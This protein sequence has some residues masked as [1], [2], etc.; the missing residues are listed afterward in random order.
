[1]THRFSIVLIL[2]AT[3]ACAQR[4]SESK[5]SL[6]TFG[7]L[8]KQHHIQLT[9]P[10]LSEALRNP[11][12]EVRDLAAQK[13]AE[14]KAY[15]AIPAINAALASEQVPRTRMNIAFAIAQLGET[16]GFDVLERNCRDRQA[17]TGIRARSA[18]Y[19]LRL[20]RES[21]ACF[22]ALLGILRTGSDGYKVEAASL[23]SRFRK[24]PA[25]DSEKAFG[26]LVQALRGSSISVRIAASQALAQLGDRRD[27][28]KLQDAAAGEEEEAV[29]VEIEEDLRKLEEQSTH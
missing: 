7:E 1:M 29:R 20:D 26:E 6:P 13:L 10:A 25:Q 24:V 2:A 4:A 14:D 16:T 8:L 22:E 3:L 11:D 21:T 17:Q 23:L 9:E 19:L 28:P 18:E 27:I 12:P 15:D 5:G